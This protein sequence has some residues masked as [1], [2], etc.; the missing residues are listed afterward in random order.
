MSDTTCL[1]LCAKESAYQV[2]KIKKSQSRT[3]TE[4]TGGRSDETSR[5]ALARE[6]QQRLASSREKAYRFSIG[7]LKA[8]LSVKSF[9]SLC[10]EPVVVTVD[11]NWV[12]LCIF[13]PP[14]FSR[15]AWH[16]RVPFRQGN[17]TQPRLVPLFPSIVTTCCCS[18]PLV[19]YH[20]VH[21]FTS[22]EDVIAGD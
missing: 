13:L 7:V 15:K 18:A 17:G 5:P 2:V 9:L 4:T 21:R 14:S 19:A 1:F 22:L 10:K 11:R 3:K 20:S 16:F 8:Q 12:L 6:L